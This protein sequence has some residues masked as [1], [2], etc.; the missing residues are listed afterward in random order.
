MGERRRR[1]REG[2]RKGKL[3][4]IFSCPFLSSATKRRRK[5]EREKNHWRFKKKKTKKR[6]KMNFFVYFKCLGKFKNKSR[7]GELQ[8][9][10][11]GKEKKGIIFV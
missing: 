9:E 3:K 1:G 8:V 4:C 6:R 7:I 11:R 5:E 10:K 2:E